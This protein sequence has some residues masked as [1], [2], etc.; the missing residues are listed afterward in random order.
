M[1][2]RRSEDCT[3]H[4]RKV[5]PP[6]SCRDAREVLDSHGT[7]FTWWRL[8]RGSGGLGV[9]LRSGSHSRMQ[10]SLPSGSVRTAH[11]RSWRRSSARVAPSS[12]A[13]GPP[14]G[15][16]GPRHPPTRRRSPPL[17]GRRQHPRPAS[18]PDAEE[19]HGHVIRRHPSPP[20]PGAPSARC[21]HTLRTATTRPHP[22]GPRLT[23]WPRGRPKPP[24]APQPRQSDPPAPAPHPLG[25]RP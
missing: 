22:R 13:R 23:Q 18:P 19:R 8:P 10:N 21:L 25:H 24:T 1:L 3:R 11:P 4:A 7:S 14:R 6:E 9:A 20:S 16:P 2:S 17:C 5:A 12:R 15:S